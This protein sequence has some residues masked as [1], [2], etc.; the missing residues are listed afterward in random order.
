[1]SN[2]L[3][4]LFF[5]FALKEPHPNHLTS[6]AFILHCKHSFFSLIGKDLFYPTRFPNHYRG[7]SFSCPLNDFLSGLPKGCIG[8]P[9]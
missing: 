2:R 9:W 8:F 5:T 4:L 7:G 1:M 3:L 6:G